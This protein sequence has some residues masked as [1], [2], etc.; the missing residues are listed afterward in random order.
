M[1]RSSNGYRKRNTR[2]SDHDKGNMHMETGGTGTKE[3]TRVVVTLIVTGTSYGVQGAREVLLGVEMT[4]AGLAGRMMGRTG[5]EVVVVV[6]GVVGI[7]ITGGQS[8]QSDMGQDR[9]VVVVVVG[10]EG[11]ATRMSDHVTEV[12]SGG[13]K[14]GGIEMKRTETAIEAETG[15]GAETGTG[16]D[17]PVEKTDVGTVTGSGSG[18]KE[19]IATTSTIIMT[20]TEVR[21]EGGVG[22]RDTGPEKGIGVPLGVVGVLAALTAAVVTHTAGPAVGGLMA[23]RVVELSWMMR[24]IGIA[25]PVAMNAPAAAEWIP[26]TPA[27]PS[28]VLASTRSNNPSEVLCLQNK[29]ICL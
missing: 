25:G 28:R 2:R 6:G 24:G 1:R 16:T 26:D 8:G 15:I 29:N 27:S 14:M 3:T 21:A 7:V 23:A 17:R 11:I 5:F 19:G 22:S 18:T 12:E 20:E 9:V 4:G 10:I 13:M